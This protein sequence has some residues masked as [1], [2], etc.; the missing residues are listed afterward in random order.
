MNARYR[1]FRRASG[2][3]YLEDTTTQQ[4]TSLKTR[5]KHE[6]ARLTHARNEAHLQPQLNRRIAQAYLAASDPLALTRTWQDVMD[7]AVQLKSGANQVRWASAIREPAL[8]GLSKVPLLETQA[9]HL[10]KAL[11]QGTVSTNVYLRRLHNFAL[12]MSWLPWPVI[13]KRQWPAV[14][15]KAKRAITRQE[16]QRIVAREPNPERRAYYELIWHLGGAQGDMANLRASDIDWDHQT[17]SFCRQKTKEVSLLRFGESVAAILRQLPQIGPL[18]PYLRTVRANDRATE[19]HQRCVGLGIQGV[20]LH[21][22]RY[23]W[24]ERARVAGMPER[25]AMEAL[26]HNSKAVHHAYS[27][28]A[29][30]QVPSLEEYEQSAAA[31]V[32]PMA[33][34]AV[35]A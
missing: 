22:Y 26:G 15:F 23:A 7:A 12:D 2:V 27:R 14:R 3:F 1:S 35:G 25:F 32:V 17:I 33:R 18:F 16:H 20:S 6:A 29:L 30:V 11:H 9:D 31:K 21:S 5:D 24:A 28:R 8:L 19:F 4:Q 34:A 10:L 13:P